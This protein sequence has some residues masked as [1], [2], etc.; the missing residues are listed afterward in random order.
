MSHG[1][2]DAA[3]AKALAYLQSNQRPDGSFVTYVSKTERS[4]RASRQFTTN[5]TP[6]LML[7]SLSRIVEA[8]PICD[9]LAAWLLLQK[10][11]NWS[12]NY[13]AQNAPERKTRPYP[14]DLDDTFCALYALW[15]HD[16]GIIDG[17]GLAKAVRLLIAAEQEVGGPYRTWLASKTATDW[18]GVDLVVNCNV[19]NFLQAV[20]EPLP[21]LTGMMD[22]AIRKKDF[23]SSYYPSQYAVWFFLARACR[24]S[25]RGDLAKL[26]VAKRRNGHWGTPARTALASLA[27]HYLGHSDGQQDRAAKYLLDT[28][29]ADGSWSAEAFWLDEAHGR[30]KWFAGSPALTTAFIVETLAIV[31]KDKPKTQAIV[32]RIPLEYTEVM[33]Y[34]TLQIENLE[35]PLRTHM[36]TMVHHM[37]AGDTN[38]EIA[39]LPHFFARSTANQKIKKNV[40]V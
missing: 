2:V 40:L 6:A 12:F 21:K 19:A 32:R 20:A 34:V 25:S 7:S 29:Q 24:G 5:F 28:Q 13:W 8:K 30:A 17:A 14:D 3:T 15:Q 11:S 22:R 9:K 39:L 18:Q 16:P 35:S 4:F 33:D 10:N 1:R 26:I 27:L 37:Q 23:S 36:Q 31:K 38:H